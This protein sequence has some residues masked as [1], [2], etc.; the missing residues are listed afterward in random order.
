MSKMINL[1]MVLVFST[2][3]FSTTYYVNSASGLNLAGRDGSKDFPWKTISYGIA[4]VSAGSTLDISG[5]FLLMDDALTTAN[6]IEITKDLTII[7]HGIG[8]TFVDAVGSSTR[9]FYVPVGITAS[10]ERMTI[11]NGI[12]G[13]H[14]GGI[15]GNDSSTLLLDRLQVI[16]NFSG[17]HG[18]GVSAMGLLMINNSDISYNIC[19]NSGGGIY[20]SGANTTIANSTVALNYSTGDGTNAIYYENL[21][22]SLID[23]I[24]ENTTISQNGGIGTGSTVKFYVRPNSAEMTSN[25]LINSSTFAENIGS[26]AVEIYNSGTSYHSEVNLSIKNSIFNNFECTLEYESTLLGDAVTNG[27]K[28]YTIT[29]DY[30]IPYIGIGNRQNTYVIYSSLADNGG[31]TKTH[32][33]ERGSLA[34]NAISISVGET[35]YNGAPTTDQRGVGIYNR[36]KDI[37]AYESEI[38]NEKFF[39][40]DISGDDANNGSIGSPWKTL[41]HALDNIVF[42]DTLKVEGDFVDISLSVKKDVTII[43]DGANQ[44]NI[45]GD[46]VWPIFTVYEDI[47]LSLKDVALKDGN[48]PNTG[49]GIDSEGN[50]YLNGVEISNCTSDNEGGAISFEYSGRG[51]SV[52]EMTNSTITGNT[53]GNMGG[54]I[55]ISSFANMEV[56]VTNST[57]SGNE[58]QND[59]AGIY[60]STQSRNDIDGNLL[61]VLRNVN[62]SNNISTTGGNSGIK[63]FTYTVGSIGAANLDFIIDN[64]ILSNGV[65]NNYE[66]NSSLG[67]TINLMRLFSI[68]QDSTMPITGTGNLN[69][70]D[71]MLAPLD[72]YNG[73]TTRTHAL[74]DGSPAIDAIAISDG[75]GDYNGAPLLDQ[76]GIAII[77]NMKDIGSFEGFIS[78]SLDTPQNVVSS[79]LGTILT[80]DWNTV[81]GASSYD[82]YV[83]DDPYGTF[84]YVESVPSNTWTTST[85]PQNKLF[86]YIIAN[87]SVK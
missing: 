20:S 46:N 8:T 7:G 39:V 43:G 44:T 54:G 10:L 52:F 56:Y 59:G 41:S 19:D 60:I 75:T 67:G 35:A 14:G 66:Q 18:G 24:L 28:S 55:D 42:N 36:F 71:P 33:L 61:V 63:T 25:V 6:G 82:I 31:Y 47:N 3:L 79:V 51:T 11:Q 32:A 50:L 70:T 58:S 48:T 21:S 57:I 5:T 37:G 49:G 29:S 53:A 68:C 30:S 4:R 40:S 38:G 85:D 84:S 62:V 76:N 87:S 12:T 13:S 1:I 69:D 73:G 45:I 2:A 9:V 26:N 16:N 83:S 77:N 86:Y 80:L 65:S 64:S 23:F 15:F 17:F 74:Y 27:D 72:Y 81:T 22:D 34:V 78:G